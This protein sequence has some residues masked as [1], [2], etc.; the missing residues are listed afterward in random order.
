MRDEAKNW[1]YSLDE[2][3]LEGNLV[4]DL[5]DKEVE[6]IP[7]FPRVKALLTDMEY[8]VIV[9]HYFLDF[10]LSQIAN[11]LKFSLIYIKKTNVNAK[12]KLKVLL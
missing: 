4:H 9:Y 10:S 6:I 2:R 12:E 3:D 8:K 11:A 5:P 7:E 1:L